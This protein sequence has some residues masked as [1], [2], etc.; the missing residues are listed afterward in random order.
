MKKIFLS[1]LAIGMFFLVSQNAILL[2]NAEGTTGTYNDFLKYEITDGEV[3]IID[4][5]TSIV[6]F[7]FPTEIAGCPVTAIGSQAFYQCINLES[8]TIPEGVTSIGDNAFW[9]CI[10][11]TSI[12]IPNSIT[13]FGI[14]PF[15]GCYSLSDIVLGDSVT[16][17]DTSLDCGIMFNDTAYY[18]NEANWE[19][20]VLYI[21]KN[22]IK[23]KTDI[24]SDCVIKDGTKNIVCDAFNGCTELSSVT[25]PE[26]LISIGS[27]AFNGCTGLTSVNIPNS[28]TY[29]G[30]R[31][32]YGCSSIQNI[33]IP[34]S[35]VNIGDFAFA[36]CNNLLD[37]YCEVESQPEEWRPYWY[38]DEYDKGSVGYNGAVR[39]T[40]WGY[41][42]DKYKNDSLNQTSEKSN[43][44]TSDNNIDESNN[45][46]KKNNKVNSNN[47]VLYIVLGSLVLLSLV[48]V[49]ATILV[50]KKRK[51]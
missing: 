21:G 10:N 20:G 14:S 25:I 19:N 29:I 18:K 50:Q 5:E 32:F 46:D 8:I 9:Q 24:S 28:V 17:I 44:E 16:C 39:E 13:S 26:S 15:A 49:G 22:V 43:A 23:A 1:L 45:Y 38:S 41:S 34:N 42:F 7:V 3:T 51:N 31:A 37:I 27:Y 6:D 33:Y 11:L 47:S 35:V 48:G 30:Q 12:T 4:C 2:V 40:H 36:G